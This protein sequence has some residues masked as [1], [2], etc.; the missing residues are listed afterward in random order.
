MKTACHL[1]IKQILLSF[2]GV[3]ILT[4]GVVTAQ[5]GM[6]GISSSNSGPNAFSGV[7]VNELLGANR[8]YSEGYTGTRAIVATIEGPV[9]R[10]THTTMSN[11]TEL[12][13]G[14]GVA[15]I[16]YGNNHNHAT[17]VSHMMSGRL[18]GPPTPGTYYGYGI[19]YG[20][21][22]WGGAI[23]TG[24][25]ANGSYQLTWES[26]TSP[27]SDMLVRG[28]NGR[29]VDVINSSW[30]YGDTAGNSRGAVGVD[31]LAFQ[32]G[33]ILVHI[34]GNGGPGANTV[35]G[36]GSGY[37]GITVGS[38]GSDTNNPPY[39]TVS[40]FSSRGASDFAQALSPSTWSIIPANIAR[41]ATV[42]I[43][44]PGQNLTV[45]VPSGGNTWFGFNWQGTSFAAPIVAGGA[46]LLVDVGRDIYGSTA[47]IDARVVKAVLMNSASKLPG[48]NNGQQLVGSLITTDQALDFNTGAGRLNL[49]QAYDQYVHTNLGGVAGTSDVAGTFR[50]DLGIVDAVGWDFGVVDTPGTNLYYID[51]MLRANSNFTSTLTWFSDRDP[52]DLDNFLGAGERSLANLDMRIFE[53]DNLIDRNFV[54]YVAESVSLYNV[55]EHLSFLIPSKGYFGIEVSFTGYHWNFFGSS[56]VAYGLAWS[57][58]SVPEPGAIS[59]LI[60]AGILVI[61]RRRRRA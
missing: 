31:G 48:W 36:F 58:T 56:E 35:N 39:E 60:A 49:S 38:L 50:G 4:S 12:V 55:S 25:N 2:L 54:G 27:Y 6:P 5:T 1:N 3:L 14:T 33:K 20:A 43:S 57:G 7:N 29:T 61:S 46:G 24:F 11:V 51:N 28:V 42:D 22:T 30:W 32:T 9:P 26:L 47:A 34:A 18:V 13:F 44:A 10:T 37:N 59:F 19:A 23:A 45:A 41:R 17:A 40:S 52:G 53:F 21:E 8:F 15:N 16:D